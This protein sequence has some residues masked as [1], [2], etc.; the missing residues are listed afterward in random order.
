MLNRSS[1]R[2]ATII[3]AGFCTGGTISTVVGQD[4]AKPTEEKKPLW[5][6]S[7]NAG[8]T[9]TRGNSENLLAT[10]GINTQRKWSRD[11]ILMGAAAAYGTTTVKQPGPDEENTTDAYAKGF[12]QFNHLFTQRFYGALRADALNDEIADVHYRFSVAPLAGYYFIKSPN[13]TLSGDAGPAWVVEKVGS[14]GPRGYL[15]VR[16]GE[17]FEHKFQNGARVWQTADITPEVE[18]WENYVLNAELGVEAPLTKKTSAR[19]VLQDTY[20]HQPSPG[21]EKND[22]KL[23]AGLAYKF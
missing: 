4:A 15:G 21:R 22:L 10:A 1:L 12:G 20:D 8:V 16:V 18:N 3:T 6:T 2:T 9:L 13:T 14:A 5:E 7:A 23:I 17:R 19:L 11:E